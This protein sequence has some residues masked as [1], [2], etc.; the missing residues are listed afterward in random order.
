MNRYG[1]G[2][3]GGYGGGGFGRGFGGYRGPGGRGN[4]PY[5]YGAG[6]NDNVEWS[7]S[8]DEEEDPAAVRARVAEVYRRHY[9]NDPEPGHGIAGGPGRPGEVDSDAL[10]AQLHRV[11][12]ATDHLSPQEGRALMIS[13]HRLERLEESREHARHDRDRRMRNEEFER[14]GRR[15]QRIT[16]HF[17][18][19]Q[20]AIPRIPAGGRAGLAA[21]PA[22]DHADER[23]GGAHEP[24]G[25]AHEHGPHPGE[26]DSE[27]VRENLARI[28]D[29]VPHVTPRDQD[30]FMQAFANLDII[31]EDRD[32]ARNAAERAE[33]NEELHCLAQRLQRVELR[34]TGQQN[35]VPIIPG[36]GAGGAEP[37]PRRGPRNGNDNGNGNGRPARAAA[38]AA[39]AARAQAGGPPPHDARNNDARP[40]AGPAGP[41]AAH[42]NPPAGMRPLS[43]EDARLPPRNTAVT[44]PVIL[45][46]PDG[47]A[48]HTFHLVLHN[49][50]P[51]ARALAAETREAA[52]VRRERNPE[53]DDVVVSVA[54][55]NGSLAPV[56]DGPRGRIYATRHDACDPVGGDGVRGDILIA[57]ETMV[58]SGDLRGFEFLG[59]GTEGSEGR[60]YL[61]R[62]IE[63]E[64][65]AGGDGDAD[66]G[67]PDE[68]AGGLEGGRG[69]GRAGVAGG[70]GG[71]AGGFGDGGA[72]GGGGGWAG[73]RERWQMDPMEADDAAL[74]NIDR[75]L[76][77]V[78]EDRRRMDAG[79]PR[80]PRGYGRRF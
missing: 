32:H 1:Y 28:L 74:R 78:R 51:E 10:L 64:E 11:L 46:A 55:E 33:V 37:D 69:E 7:S 8:S 2:G 60:L 71:G 30:G 54:L 13:F 4:H 80:R 5:G 21:P 44:A 65:D 45:H 72:G 61:I 19:Q 42:P 36:G 40:A 79:L 68:L 26:V 24:A 58:G 38:A 50:A 23:A 25:P 16:L 53:P 31:E 22:N 75:M 43:A 3:H 6:A 57:V 56:S 52:R 27:T 67:G 9:E 47:T 70:G 48:A 35:P 49:T 62:P 76:E 59:V 17:M 66:G 73:R 41:R 14:L 77:W 12:Q 39:A 29:T 63:G 34:L 18:G 20:F 15:I